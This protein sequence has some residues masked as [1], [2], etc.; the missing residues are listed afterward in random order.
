MKTELRLSEDEIVAFCRKWGIREMAVFGSVLRPDFGS[1]SDIDFLISFHK[2]RKPLWP[3]ILDMQD[4]LSALVARP[5][6]VIDRR[7]LEKS[8]KK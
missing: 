8:E 4:E 1:E 5:V 2:E 6:D 7:N 3:L